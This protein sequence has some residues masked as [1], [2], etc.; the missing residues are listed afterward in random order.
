[1]SE[2]NVIQKP[3]LNLSLP[4]A[5]TKLSPREIKDYTERMMNMNSDL[6]RSIN[7][8]SSKYSKGRI[9]KMKSLEK[10]FRAIKGTLK[11]QSELQERIEDNM[12]LN[13]LKA[14]MYGISPQD[15][16]LQIEMS[17]PKNQR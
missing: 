5:S 9:S 15:Q 8:K 12:I 11:T 4:P 10:Y 17:D 14:D 7:L 1:M 13:K 6:Y 2:V 3:K 16:E